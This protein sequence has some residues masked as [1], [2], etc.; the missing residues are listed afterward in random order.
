MIVHSPWSQAKSGKYRD[1][2]ASR[3]ISTDWSVGYRQ[4]GGHAPR[5]C[6]NRKPAT[7]A[8]RAT[9]A[10][11]SFS[12]GTEPAASVATYGIPWAA[13]IRAM[14]FFWPARG[15][16]AGVV[17]VHAPSGVAPDFWTPVFMYASL[18]LS[19]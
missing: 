17:V 4:P 14:S 1:S 11:K 7:S 6:R 10:R 18:S 13:M 2:T 9:F 5:T 19:T 8:A 16:A 12:I 3:A 15:A